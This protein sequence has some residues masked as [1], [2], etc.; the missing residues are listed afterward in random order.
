MRAHAQR[1]AV[2]VRGRGSRRGIT[3]FLYHSFPD[4]ASTMPNVRREQALV[5]AS[6]D[7][8]LVCADCC[9]QPHPWTCHACG[10]LA[11]P[12]LARACPRVHSS[13]GASRAGLTRGR[14]PRDAEALLD[15]FDVESR[16]MTAIG[17]TR[18]RSAGVPRRLS[19]GG[20]LTH[21]A[22]DDEATAQPQ[23]S[24]APFSYSPRFCRP[25]TQS[26]TTPSRGLFLDSGACNPRTR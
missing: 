19:A 18:S 15:Y 2:R 20:N 14:G 4:K 24:C 16:P 23:A 5:G 8:Q 12:L 1:P 22:L 7:D 25:V 3:P 11:A 17:W 6:G 21:E 10:V 26:S 9:G 13:G